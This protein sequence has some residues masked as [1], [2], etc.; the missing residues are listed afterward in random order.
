MICLLRASS[1]ASERQRDPAGRSGSIPWRARRARAAPG[2]ARQAAGAVRSVVDD[3]AALD[4]ALL[5]EVEGVVDP[6]ERRTTWLARNPS[7][8]SSFFGSTSTAMIFAAP[9]SRAAWMVLRPTPPQPNTATLA[10]GGTLARFHTG[11]APARTPQLTRQTTSSGASRRTGMTL[12][13][14]TTER[15]A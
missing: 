11:P 6:A 4:L 14:S 7:A 3:H 13:S 1:S 10:P 2:R 15:V 9:T 8:H 5:Q 12:S